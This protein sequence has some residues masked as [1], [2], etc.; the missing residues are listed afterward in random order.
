M[1][2]KY[3]TGDKVWVKGTVDNAM[4]KDGKVYYKIRECEELI[5]E[6][7]CT[8]GS[9]SLNLKTDAPNI[10]RAIEKIQHMRGLLKEAM[11]IADSIASLNLDLRINAVIDDKSTELARISTE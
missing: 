1:I 7:I 4:N 8:S 10:D 3:D 5:P 11:D 6:D 9:I 2:T